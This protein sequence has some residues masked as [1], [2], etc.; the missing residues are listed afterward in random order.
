VQQERTETKTRLGI[1]NRKI[2][3]S[4]TVL[5]VCECLSAVQ[6]SHAPVCSM[7]NVSVTHGRTYG[8]DQ[9]SLDR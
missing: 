1:G 9:I 6:L 5:G 4:Q 3:L 8:H 7:S 2:G